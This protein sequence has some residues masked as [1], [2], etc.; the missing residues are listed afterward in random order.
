MKVLIDSNRYFDL[1][2]G[3]EAVRD[4]LVAVDEIYVPLIVLAELRGGFAHGT[5]RLENEARLAHFLRQESVFVLKPD[6]QTTYL[7]ADLF[8]YLRGRGTPVP[9]ND[10]WIASLALQ[11]NLVLFDRDTDF[12]RMPQ[13]ARVGPLDSRAFS[14]RSTPAESAE[15]NCRGRPSAHH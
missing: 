15:P 6:E 13:I 1:M 10:L 8:A 2:H 14:N 5:R 9:T 7:Y 4:F 12:D 3:S 11:H